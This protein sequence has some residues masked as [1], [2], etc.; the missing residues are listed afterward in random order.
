MAVVKVQLP[1]GEIV[2][3]EVPDSVK[4][5]PNF[6]E[7]FGTNLKTGAQKTGAGLA[8]LPLLPGRLMNLGLEKLYKFKTGKDATGAASGIGMG[9]NYFDEVAQQADKE[10]KEKGFQNDYGRALVEAI[11]GTFLTPGLSVAPK[12]AIAANAIPAVGA[13]AARD[14]GGDMA[15][16]IAGPTLGLLSGFAFGPSLSSAESRVNKAVRDM[17]SDDFSRARQN[18]ATTQAGGAQTATLPD[19]VPHGRLN[20]LANET[21]MFAPD[22][23]FAR[24]LDGRAEDLQQLGQ[25]A[26]AGAGNV[27]RP[28][29]ITSRA[30]LLANQTIDQ[31]KRGFSKQLQTSLDAIPPIPQP[32]MNAVYEA[33]QNHSRSAGVPLDFDATAVRGAANALRSQNTPGMMVPGV[34]RM[35]QVTLPSGARVWRMETPPP[36]TLPGLLERPS[37][38]SLALTQWRKAQNPQ[39]AAPGAKVVGERAASDAVRTANMAIDAEAP[40]YLKAKTA[41]QEAMRNVIDPMERGPLGVLAGPKLD[42]PNRVTK[43]QLDSVIS[44]LSP[45]GVRDL[46]GALR[47]TDSQAG[48]SNIGQQIASLLVQKRLNAGSSNPGQTVAGQSGFPKDANFSAVLDASGI[49]PQAIRAPLEAADL[50]QNFRNPASGAGQVPISKLGAL[51]R[52]FRHGDFALTQRMRDDYYGEISRLFADPQANLPRLQEI[53]MFDPNVRRALSMMSAINA[54]SQQQGN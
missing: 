45:E 14:L 35:T 52:P 23:A 36:Q 34:P 8:T 32:R 37:D 38:I 28:E 41:Y 40:G 13:E 43:G 5:E 9:P 16:N 42:N 15:A 51:L 39:L 27:A 30:A 49:N 53:A 25:R 3:V 26:I 4:T 29:D 47:T 33:L 22:S 31:T 19:I 21:R 48:P 20:E 18:L 46:I 17:T 24:R 12:A 50:L 1:N 54:N 11:P 2:S 10:G 44:E 7:K 6:I